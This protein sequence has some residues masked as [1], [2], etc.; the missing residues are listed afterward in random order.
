M[1][2]QWEP[3]FRMLDL[4]SGLGGASEAMIDDPRW[5]VV[6]IEN[7]P[8]L[9]Q[10]PFTHQLDVL[11]WTDWID[12]LGPFD[13]VWASPPCLEFSDGFHA[14]KSKARRAGDPYVPDLRLVEAAREIITVINPSWY[15]IENV[16]GAREFF[17]PLMG[18]PTQRIHAFHLW[19]R[20]PHITIPRD[21]QPPKKTDDWNIGDPLRANYRALIP[22]MISESF[23][24]AIES[25]LRIDDRKA[26]WWA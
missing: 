18:P 21:W 26:A 15:V 11:E 3:E 12:S 8:L 22:P 7:N 10:V 6:R 14:P 19:G 13:V 24:R 1:S 2:E 4:F 16:R 5:D 20:F 23:K 17:D 9:Q 25:Q